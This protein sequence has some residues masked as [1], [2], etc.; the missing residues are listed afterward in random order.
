[1]RHSDPEGLYRALGI[2]PTA[3]QEEIKNAYRR[4]AKETHPDTSSDG[5]SFQFH[6]IYNA[7]KVLSDAHARERYDRRFAQDSEDHSWLGIEPVCCSRCGSMTAQPRKL[8]FVRVYSAI[9]AS[10]RRRVEGIYCQRC[11]QTEA[12]KS[13]VLSAVF[14]WWGLPFAPYFTLRAIARNA[15]GGTRDMAVE[16]QLLWQNSRAF[17]AK[18]NRKLSYALAR[19]L[20]EAGDSEVAEGARELVED[21]EARG[22]NPRKIKLKDPWRI[23]PLSVMTHLTLAAVLPLGIGGVVLESL[24]TDISEETQT[25]AEMTYAAAP[26]Q[27]ADAMLPETRLRPPPLCWKVPENGEVLYRIN[28]RVSPGHS[29][30]LIN[31]TPEVAIV[32]VRSAFAKRLIAAVYMVAN[33][34]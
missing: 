9:F 33:A 15:L 28:P 2:T 26:V 16:E 29:I 7:Y 11:A 4:L 19:K 22:A 12:V 18:G 25:A 10:F 6:K 27:P 1:M 21:M 3:D 30:T 14:G 34:S 20:T 5:S 32:K 17:A 8:S 23:K 24:Q 31:D 13:S